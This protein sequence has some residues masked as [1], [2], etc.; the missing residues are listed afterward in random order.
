[1]D[2]MSLLGI[3][4]G[5]LTTMSFLPQVLKTWQ[6]RSAKD[7]SF[8]MLGAFT[9]GVLLWVIYGFS[10]GSLPIIVTN[11]ATLM[12]AAALLGMKMKFG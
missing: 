6:S 2:S 9:S 12:L 8:W 4:A 10:I 3:A 1:M 5:A 7:F 11:I